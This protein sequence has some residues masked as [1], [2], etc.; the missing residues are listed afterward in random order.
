M[1]G[2]A[3]DRPGVQAALVVAGPQPI[4]PFDQVSGD[5]DSVM[6]AMDKIAVGSHSRRLGA[7]TSMAYSILSQQEGI[8]DA[9]L[10]SF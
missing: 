5:V 10:S 1:A 6:E 2:N 3:L 9:K 4:A 8:E 7:A